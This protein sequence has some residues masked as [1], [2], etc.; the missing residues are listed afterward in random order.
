M[1]RHILLTGAP[2]AGKTT[3]IRA[4]EA[5]GHSA[6]PE[7]ATDVIARLQAAGK[8]RPWE[9]AGFPEA[10][11]QLQRARLVQAETLPGPVFHDRSALCTLALARFLGHPVGP[12]LKAAAEEA[13]AIFGRQAFMVRLMGFVTPSEARKIDLAGA[14][15]FEAVHE[16]VY[17]EHGFTLIEVP[18]AP[19]E[20]R[21][22]QILAA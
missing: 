13:A 19:V 20:M 18:P 14:L 2:G 4:L 6:V 21:L 5:L 22:A 3:L 17:A 11:A 9:D 1:T 10:I 15:A 7:A 12:V 16:A 8:D